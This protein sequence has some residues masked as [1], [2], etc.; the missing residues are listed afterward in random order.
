MDNF[1]QIFVKNC[2]EFKPFEVQI[3]KSFHVILVVLSG[4]NMIQ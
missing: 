4:S 1:E 2:K 3:V